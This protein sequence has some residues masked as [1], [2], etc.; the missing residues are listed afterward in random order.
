MRKRSMP[1]GK[2]YSLLEPGPVVLL[3]T[4]HQGKNNVMTMSWH[5]MMDFEPPL[6]GCVV[7]ARNFSFTALRSTR[8]CVLNIPTREIAA[9]VV[10]CGNVSGRALDKF[11]AF[12]LMPMPASMVDAP[13]IAQCYASLECRAVD[14]RLVN[15]YN[16]FILEVVKA[17]IVSKCSNPQTLHHRGH[18]NFMIAGEAVKFPSK[19]K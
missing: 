14:M 5:T 4:A 16:F 8:Q 11:A 15:R 9:Q 12:G 2:V 7:S 17:W 18:G 10:Q 6:L 3:S 1:L 19:M 13:L